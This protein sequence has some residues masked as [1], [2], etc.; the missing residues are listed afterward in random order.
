MRALVQHASDI[1]SANT[2]RGH[3]HQRSIALGSRDLD[4]LDNDLAW[5]VQDT[6][7]HLLVHASPSPT[8]SRAGRVASPAAD[9]GWGAKRLSPVSDSAFSS[10]IKPVPASTYS[11][12]SSPLASFTA[13]SMVAAPSACG[14]LNAVA[15]YWS[16]SAIAVTASIR[17]STPKTRTS[18]RSD[19]L[20]TCMAPRAM[21]SLWA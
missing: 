5:A 7:L 15:T 16:P 14:S 3:L 8:R 10:L 13:V 18:S 4:L 17:P 21:S 2:A 20:S 9:Y 1:G 12:T 11:G 6:C 19:S